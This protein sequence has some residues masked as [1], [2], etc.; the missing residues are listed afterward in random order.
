MS[1]LVQDSFVHDLVWSVTDFSFLAQDIR[2]VV[3]YES[4]YPEEQNLLMYTIRIFAELAKSPRI[5]SKNLQNQVLDIC[6]EVLGS[7]D[8]FKREVTTWAIVLINR[9][10][11]HID[12]AEQIIEHCLGIDPPTFI[13]FLLDICDPE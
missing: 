6:V 10:T 1:L 4:L 2:G 12:I 8:K 13:T 3:N 5:A 11:T 7:G 9:S